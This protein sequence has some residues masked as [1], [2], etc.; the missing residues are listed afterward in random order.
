MYMG[1]ALDKGSHSI[2]LRYLTPGLKVG[3]YIS[4]GSVVLLFFVFIGCKRRYK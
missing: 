1:I 3:C 4:L 2:E